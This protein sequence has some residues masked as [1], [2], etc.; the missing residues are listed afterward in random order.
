MKGFWKATAIYSDGTTKTRMFP[1]TSDGKF[2][3]DMAERGLCE[4]RMFVNPGGKIKKLT[5]E[6]VKEI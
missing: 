6:H 1:Y 2:H 5:V 3:H 4:R